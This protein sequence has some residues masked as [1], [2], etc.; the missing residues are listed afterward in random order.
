MEKELQER[1]V[2][3]EQEARERRQKGKQYEQEALER[4]TKEVLEEDELLHVDETIDLPEC[5][6]DELLGQRSSIQ[7]QIAE[8][9]AKLQKLTTMAEA[10]TT[11]SC[12]QAEE[13][14]VT[15]Q[16]QIFKSPAVIKHKQRVNVPRCWNCGVR[17]HEG[18]ECIETTRKN[19]RKLKKEKDNAMLFN[20]IPAPPTIPELLEV[21]AQYVEEICCLE[22]VHRGLK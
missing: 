18:S 20:L 17:G 4:Q 6:E 3:R 11:N 9:D 1:Q 8:I 19:A 10:A 13:T 21:S 5:D 15:T 2:R 12:K 22:N 14:I 7:Q 16:P